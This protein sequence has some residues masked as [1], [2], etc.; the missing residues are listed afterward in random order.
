LMVQVLPWC[1]Q[2]HEVIQ[3]QS[4]RTIDNFCCIG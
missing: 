3:M 1:L 2:F 4:G